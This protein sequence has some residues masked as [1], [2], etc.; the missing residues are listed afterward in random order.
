MSLEHTK[1]CS[2]VSS[3][4]DQQIILLV[5]NNIKN[6]IQFTVCVRGWCPKE[7][8][9]ASSS[10]HVLD[11]PELRSD[12]FT[13]V[14]WDVEMILVHKTSPKNISILFV[15]LE[16][17][18][19]TQSDLGAIHWESPTS[20]VSQHVIWCGISSWRGRHHGADVE[21]EKRCRSDAFPLFSDLSDPESSALLLPTLT[22]HISRGGD[23]CLLGV[24]HYF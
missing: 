21:G 9:E 15:F 4:L 19:Q 12:Q 8:S 18:F 10:P 7:V 6:R 23:G 14:G 16:L 5:P 22:C 24:G 17:W 11:F 2:W 1:M 20:I 3:P 13:P